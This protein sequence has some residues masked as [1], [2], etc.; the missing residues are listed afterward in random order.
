MKIFFNCTLL[1]LLSFF[2]T[3]LI[4]QIGIGTE[5][6]DNSAALDISS[7]NKGILIP[8]LT[9]SQR[10]DISSP[11]EGL[12]IFNTTTK[13]INIY[14]GNSWL[15]I[16]SGCITPTTATA[17]SDQIINNIE[18]TTLQGNS[19]ATSEFGIW[20]IVSC[21][22][23]YEGYWDDKT[24]ADAVFSGTQGVTYVL[25]WTITN[26]C[27]NTSYD[28]VQIEFACPTGSLHTYY[29]DNDHDGYGITTQTLVSCIMPLGY[30][31][32]GGDCNDN[33]SNFNPGATEICNDNL[34][35]DCDS[36][37]DEQPC[38]P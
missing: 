38:N 23:G 5:T 1:L 31:V 29:L 3:A 20:S 21:T 11:A 14:D 28:D 18:Y 30:A 27:N 13:K 7:T 8:R 34:D 9:N 33:N 2:Q 6:P 12:F 4:A 15:E 17:G 32:V 19:P 37:I 25:R 22:E 10:N 16:S 26:N 24:K 36:Q 35:Q